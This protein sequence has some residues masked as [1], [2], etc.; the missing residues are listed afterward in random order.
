MHLPTISVEQSAEY[1][2][3]T[4]PGVQPASLALLAPLKYGI[5]GASNISGALRQDPP[6]SFSLLV[7]V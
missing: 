1:L 5:F 2:N 3:Q 4:L 6:A 7:I